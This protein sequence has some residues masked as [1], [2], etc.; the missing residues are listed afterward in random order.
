MLQNEIRRFS[1]SPVRLVSFCRIFFAFYRKGRQNEKKENFCNR[2]DTDSYHSTS[3]A[4]GSGGYRRSGGS[5]GSGGS[6][7]GGSRTGGNITGGGGGRGDPVGGGQRQV[8]G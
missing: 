3:L 7:I 1:V 6:F 4:Y 8:I 5:T 2:C